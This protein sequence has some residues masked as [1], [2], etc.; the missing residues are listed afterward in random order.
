MVERVPPVADQVTDVL[1]VPVTVAENCCVLPGWSATEEGLTATAIAA[2]FAGVLGEFA[3][4]KPLQ[5][6]PR[7]CTGLSA[8]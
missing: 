7:K 8:K 6:E 5:H 4:T 2:T 3:A 1:L